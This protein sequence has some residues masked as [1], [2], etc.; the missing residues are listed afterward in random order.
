MA[1]NSAT[2]IHIAYP[3]APPPRLRIALGP[4]RLRV[5]Q[6][7]E[8]A[9]V[10]GRYE[11]PTGMLPIRVTQAGGRATIRQSTHLGSMGRLIGSPSL[12]LSLGTG[13]PCE[14]LVEGGA[15]D[16]VLDLGGVPMARLT[17]RQGAGRI[18]VDFATPNPAEMDELDVA[19]GG[20]SMELRN[21]ANANVARMTVSG[22]AAS[23]RLQFGGRLRR[24]A[25]VRLN[26]GISAIDVVVPHDVP[27]RISSSS[28]LGGLRIGDG[29]VTREGAFWTEAGA[30]GGSPLVRIAVTSVLGAVR[31]LS[32]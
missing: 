32:A 20:V 11:D 24:D 10:T 31:L 18:R 14:L 9:F 21:L 26:A 2:D 8:G 7:A 3:A 25:E 15:N 5:G 17:L 12:D 30:S 28:V 23:Y 4:C 16:S 13:P 19:A 29:Y 6:G 1:T 22:G 27:A